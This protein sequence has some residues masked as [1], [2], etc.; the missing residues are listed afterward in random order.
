MSTLRVAGF[1]DHST[2]N[3]EG[4]RTTIFLSGCR[5]NCPGCHN[6]A[7]QDFNYG[8]TI[9]HSFL[10]SK[11]K[12]NIPLIDGIT[13]SGGDPFE[14]CESLLPFLQEVKQLNLSIWTYTGYTYEQLL[15][16]PIHKQL[17]SFIDVL[18]DGRYDA[19]KHT[20][21]HK[22]IGSTNQRI[23]NLKNGSIEKVLNY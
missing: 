11:I 20:T 21:T 2:V 13:L 10:I 23:L 8:E 22:Y 15:S 12:K 1:L 6:E 18:V 7:M 9:D 3:G 14:Q 16:H 17:L 5:H 19:S 4:F